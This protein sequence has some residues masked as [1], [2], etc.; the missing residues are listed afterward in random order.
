MIVS[1]KTANDFL[2]QQ[3]VF[4]GAGVMKLQDFFI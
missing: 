4:Y 1:L 2:L 3:M